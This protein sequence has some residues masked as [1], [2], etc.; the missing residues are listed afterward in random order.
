MVLTNHDD[1]RV[2]AAAGVLLILAAALLLTACSGA[3]DTAQLPTAAGGLG[4]VVPVEGGGRYLDILPQDLKAMLEAK[5]FFFVN[6]HVPYEGEIEQTDAFI[7]F[8]QLATRLSEFP[9]DTGAKI[10]LY[11]RSGSMS[12]IAARDMVSAGYTNIYNLDGGFRAW[13]AAGHELIQS[14]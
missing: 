9:Q 1:S 12:A 14:P 13:A 11:C 3:P 8:D 7:P 10:V 4:Q 5:D 2:R 6:V